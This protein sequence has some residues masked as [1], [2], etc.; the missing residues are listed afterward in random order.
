MTDASDAGLSA[1]GLPPPP[2]EWVSSWPQDGS[3]DPSAMHLNAAYQADVASK[4][5]AGL[6]S[7]MQYLCGTVM[8]L[9]SQV[10][11]LEDW[12][13]KALEEVRKLRDEHKMLKRQILG[14]EGKMASSGETLTVQRAQTLPGLPLTA[15]PGPPPGLA[16][17]PL[18]PAEES[19][20]ALP[21]ADPS[22]SSL[23]SSFQ[24]SR[25]FTSGSMMSDVECGQLEGLQISSVHID[26][27][28]YERA[29]WRI[30]Q[31][32][33][34]LRGCMGR[35]LVSSP[36]SIAGLEEVRLM[37]CPEGANTRGGP[38]SKRQKEQYSKKVM[39]GPLDG[40]LKLKVSSCPPDLTLQYYLKVGTS[41]QGP[42]HHNFHETTVHGCDDFGVDWLKELEPDSS[43]LVSVEIRRQAAQ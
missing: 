31:L 12:K 41:R 3:T 30:G 23:S 33:T 38:R 42:F 22:K 1:F 36:F 7:H 26:G 29:E 21:K 13:R 25:S 10:Q 15:P 5:A 11:E 27:L 17:M 34:K 6:A 2:P 37:V 24:S 43:L 35:A 18:D 16:G 14:E 19:G 39:E 20:L 9:Q 28:D 4:C 32:S 8:R 40:C